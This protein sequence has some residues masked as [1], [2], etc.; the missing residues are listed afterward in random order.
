MTWKHIVNS[1]TTFLCP[2]KSGSM[3][4]ISSVL[5]KQFLVLFLIY[6]IS[7]IV[8]SCRILLASYSTFTSFLS[9]SYSIFH[10]V[11]NHIS[12]GLCSDWCTG[13]FS[14]LLM[15][16]PYCVSLQLD[17][18]EF[19]YTGFTHAVTGNTR[20]LQLKMWLK[21]MRRNNTKVVRNIKP[22]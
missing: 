19:S 22:N 6:C 1:L 14:S 13:C 15:L 8:A 21:T 3:M 17:A 16:V 12:C 5:V 7:V 18:T 9:S 4:Y 10:R 20:L 2:S 11:W